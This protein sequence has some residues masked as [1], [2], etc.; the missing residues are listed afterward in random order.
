MKEKKKLTTIEMVYIKY[1]KVMLR[2]PIDPFCALASVYLLDKLL[3]SPFLLRFVYFCIVFS[4]ES[5]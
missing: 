5:R 3:E 4:P 1:C 2:Y